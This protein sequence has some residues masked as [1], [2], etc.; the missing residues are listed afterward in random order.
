[1]RALNRARRVAGDVEL[2][3]G[4][5]RPEKTF[6]V[7][8][9]DAERAAALLGGADRPGDADRGRPK[10]HQQIRNRPGNPRRA[11]HSTPRGPIIMALFQAHRTGWVKRRLA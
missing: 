3:S 8:G 9:I 7:R 10:S 4:R 5:A 1:M 6:R 2:V 11:C